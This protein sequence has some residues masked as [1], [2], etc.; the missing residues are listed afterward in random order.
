[1]KNLIF[2]AIPIVLIVVQY[3]IIKKRKIKKWYQWIP[4]FVVLLTSLIIG[5]IAFIF[6]IYL[7][8]FNL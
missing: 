7:G 2:W 1:M 6:Y 3:V 4:L 5:V 8:G